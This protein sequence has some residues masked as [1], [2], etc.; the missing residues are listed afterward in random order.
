MPQLSRSGPTSSINGGFEY[1][2][3]RNKLQLVA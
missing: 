2:G 3:V 1:G